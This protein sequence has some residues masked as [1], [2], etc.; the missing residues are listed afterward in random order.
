M[1]S[2]LRE[3]V[4]NL[5]TKLGKAKESFVQTLDQARDK[6]DGTLAAVPMFQVNDKFL[7]NQDEAWYTLSIETQACLDMIVLQVLYSV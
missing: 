2:S 3:E 1:H 7:L 5:E 6:S 4:V